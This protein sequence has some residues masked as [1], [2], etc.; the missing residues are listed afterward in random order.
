MDQHSDPRLSC[1]SLV[2]TNSSKSFLNICANGSL[3]LDLPL[4]G[5]PR[6]PWAYWMSLTSSP[7]V[8]SPFALTNPTTLFNTTFCIWINW[9]REESRGF[10]GLES[11]NC[12]AHTRPHSRYTNQQCQ[13][14]FTQLQNIIPNACKSLLYV[15]PRPFLEVF[16]H[17]LARTRWD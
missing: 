17:P 16:Q 11:H 8:M 7:A 10:K 13:I 12:W 1:M 4:G 2:V 5:M 3:D 9:L 6:P 14:P 15:A